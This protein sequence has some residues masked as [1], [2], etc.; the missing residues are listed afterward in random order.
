MRCL[1]G[2]HG[3]QRTLFLFKV[4]KRAVRDIFSLSGWQ[5]CEDLFRGLSILTLPSIYTLETITF[6]KQNF[7]KPN[8]LFTT[9]YSMRNKNSLTI[10]KHTTSFIPLIFN[11]VKIDKSLSLSFKL[12]SIINTSKIMLRNLL[13]GLIALVTASESIFWLILTVSLYTC[14]MCV[15]IWSI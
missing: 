5:S 7:V 11:G 4:K 8:F 13:I 9:A 3:Y 2:C 12:E 14:I 6:V 10:P 15:S 1:S